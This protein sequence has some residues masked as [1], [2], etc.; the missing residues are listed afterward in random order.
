MDL[1]GDQVSSDLLKP[2]KTTPTLI[3]EKLQ[4]SECKIKPYP[5][6]SQWAEPT[7]SSLPWDITCPHRLA[8]GLNETLVPHKC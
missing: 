1:K 4:S 6:Q 2:W 7:S 3:Q 8:H 5:S